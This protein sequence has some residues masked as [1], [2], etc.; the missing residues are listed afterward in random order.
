MGINKKIP[1]ESHMV[2]HGEVFLILYEYPLWSL[3][4]I[5]LAFFHFLW[6]SGIEGNS[7]LWYNVLIWR[8]QKCLKGE[9]S[10]LSSQGIFSLC[11][12]GEALAEA[13]FTW[14]ETS[15]QCCCL[16]VLL[17]CR[18]SFLHLLHALTKSCDPRKGF[19]PSFWDSPIWKAIAHHSY[20]GWKI[21]IPEV[22][23]LLLQ[24]GSEHQPIKWPRTASCT[25]LIKSPVQWCHEKAEANTYLSSFTQAAARPCCPLGLENPC[26]RR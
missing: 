26:V 22:N 11:S 17:S 25:A 8:P 12:K 10:G 19:V 1:L 21:R 14:E 7:P 5:H 18:L 3:L 24:D 23:S 6:P 9:N 16:W 15:L 2:E 20:Q 13:L 4:Y